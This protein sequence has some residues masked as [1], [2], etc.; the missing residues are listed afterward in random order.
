MTFPAA[1]TLSVAGLVWVLV[2]AFSSVTTADDRE[3]PSPEILNENAFATVF[4]RV[5]GLGADQ[6][7]GCDGIRNREIVDG[8]ARPWSAIGRVNFS[9]IDQRAHCTGTLIS[10]R[11]VLTAAHCFCGLVTQCT[12]KELGT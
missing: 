3:R 11:L 5:C 9:G 6:A 7:A 2:L 10:E 12:K 1:Q 4:D 8:S